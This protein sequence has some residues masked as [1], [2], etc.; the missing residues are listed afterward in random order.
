MDAAAHKPRKDAHWFVVADESRAIVYEATAKFGSLERF[1]AF[2]NRPAREKMDE[3]ISDR[4][5]RSFDSHGKGRHTLQKEKTDPKIQSVKAFAKRIAILVR[6]A[7]RNGTCAEFALIAPPKFLGMLRE[8]TQL[9]N[10]G[11]PFVSI[12]KN[13]TAKNA[14]DIQSLI[15]STLR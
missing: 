7:K 4:G 11:A 8:E 10:T 12:D 2:E 14:D 6:D 13:V 5:G 9:L 1:I 15:N 3:L